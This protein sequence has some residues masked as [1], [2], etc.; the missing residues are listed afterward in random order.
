[1]FRYISVL[2]GLIAISPTILQ[3]SFNLYSI[4]I[5][6]IGVVVVV[7]KSFFIVQQLPCSLWASMLEAFH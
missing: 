1:M 6:A 7:V 4:I 3:E 5:V 2:R